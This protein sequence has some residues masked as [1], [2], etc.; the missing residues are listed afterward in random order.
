MEE[1]HYLLYS[2]TFKY[3]EI[4]YIIKTFECAWVTNVFESYK[5]ISAFQSGRNY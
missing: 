2:I 4:V 3:V 5:I 1:N